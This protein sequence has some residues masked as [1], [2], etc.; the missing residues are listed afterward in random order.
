[1]AKKKTPKRTRAALPE[2]VYMITC[3]GVAVD[4][5]TSKTTIYGLFEKIGVLKFP[6]TI[7]RL[8]LVAKISGGIG[9]HEIS[10]AVLDPDGRQIEIKVPTFVIAC[11]SRMSGEIHATLTNLS[12]KKQGIYKIVLKSGRKRIGT[13]CKFM[14]SKIKKKR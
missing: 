7:G 12:V 2:L 11:H 10:L 3:D 6:A 4:P 9:K 1:M 14:V 8:S 5:S 13:P